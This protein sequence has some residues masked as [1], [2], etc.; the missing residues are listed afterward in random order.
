MLL[1]FRR[2]PALPVGRIKYTGTFIIEATK[3]AAHPGWTPGSK[4]RLFNRSTLHAGLLTSPIVD[5]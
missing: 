1:K 5:F 2:F 4:W 3:G